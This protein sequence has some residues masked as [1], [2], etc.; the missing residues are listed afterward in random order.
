MWNRK[1]DEEPQ[2]RISGSPTS[3]DLS[4]EGIPMQTYTTRR[5]D[6]A[7]VRT[8]AVIGKTLVVTGQLAGREDMTLDGRM[9]GDIEL[10]ENRLTVG[11]GGHV[12]GKVKAR[13]VVVYGSVNGNLDATE[14]IE[15]KRNAR[16]IGDI[17]AAR[18]VMED[19]SFFRGNVDTVR[20]EAPKVKAAAQA[21][22]PAAAAA[23]AAPAATAQGS[24]LPNSGETKK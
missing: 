7:T 11:T 3:A 20:P 2:P 8:T 13:E 1:K 15:I 12:Q 19:E 9:E 4:R 16:V 10:T 17:R 21:A 6:E 23:S 14:R 18:I 24:L 5:V 22:T